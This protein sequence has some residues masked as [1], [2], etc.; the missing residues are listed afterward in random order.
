[1]ESSGCQQRNAPQGEP[2]TVFLARLPALLRLIAAF[3]PYDPRW[4]NLRG[5]AA[6][7][8]GDRRPRSARCAPP[9]IRPTLFQMF[10]RRACLRR[11]VHLKTKA[12]RRVG[13]SE[14]G[15]WIRPPAMCS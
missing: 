9:L 4:I 6:N 11:S 14:R 7:L 15:R 12:R 13:P 2:A 10:A 1:M 8:P 3:S 5:M